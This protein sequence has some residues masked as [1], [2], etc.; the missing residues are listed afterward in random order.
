MLGELAGQDVRSQGIAVDVAEHQVV[1]TVVATE[2]CPLL[3][4]GRSMG[5][6]R[7]LRGGRKRHPS[8]ALPRL[9]PFE[10]LPD[11]VPAAGRGRSARQ[12]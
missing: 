4:L 8:S 3:S 7:F 10:V 11:M 12:V 6:Q 5:D 9:R 2:L 1:L